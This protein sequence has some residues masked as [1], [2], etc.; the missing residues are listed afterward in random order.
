V[1]VCVCLCV[2]VWDICVGQV[3]FFSKVQTHFLLFTK[4]IYFYTKSLFVFLQRIV[5]RWLSLRILRLLRSILYVLMD[6]INLKNLNL[7]RQICVSLSVIC[8]NRDLFCRVFVGND[9]MRNAIISESWASTFVASHCSRMERGTSPF[10]QHSFI[11]GVWC[12][13]FQE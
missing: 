13:P 1:C 10:V 6:D 9:C 7:G 2:Y 12:D 5:E 4:C 11:L 3:S 8:H